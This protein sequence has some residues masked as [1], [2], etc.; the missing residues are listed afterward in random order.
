MDEEGRVA[1][2]HI[3]GTV[4]V[5]DGGW[6]GG[7]GEVSLDDRGAWPDLLSEDIQPRDPMT[8][9]RE[10]RIPQLTL[11][12]VSMGMLSLGGSREGGDGVRRSA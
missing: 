5:D 4:L 10:A 6:N 1:D 8:A 12:R 7:I 9:R 11:M 3:E 2:E